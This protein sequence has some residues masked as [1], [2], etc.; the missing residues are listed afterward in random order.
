MAKLHM[1][2]KKLINRI[3]DNSLKQAN[4]SKNTNEKT[5]AHTIY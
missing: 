3:F 2:P 1:N 4:G 5:E